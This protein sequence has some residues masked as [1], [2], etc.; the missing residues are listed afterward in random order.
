M[1][2]CRICS[3]NGDHKHLTVKEM[4][5]GTRETFDYYQCVACGSVQITEP[6]P[7]GVLA[8]HYPFNYYSFHAHYHS[9]GG[10]LKAFLLARRDRAALGEMNPIG[11]AMM[12]LRPAKGHIRLLQQIGVR[13][14][15]SV[16]DVGCGS[17]ELLDQLA[18][19]GFPR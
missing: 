15:D 11:A 6:L 19:L 4:M 13:K 14:Q 16:L 1:L 3:H 7:P 9:Y 8:R 5:F 2:S 12:R 18:Q 17:G 10:G